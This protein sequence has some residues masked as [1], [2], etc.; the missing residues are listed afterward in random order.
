[1]LEK[2][3]IPTAG[4]G[5]RLLPATKEQPKEM[6]PVFV[7]A[8]NGLLYVKPFVQLVF[9]GLHDAG[10][11]NF[12][13][14][15]GRGKRSIEDHFTLD[16]NLAEHLSQTKRF[17][18]VN[19]LN[20]FYERIS[21]SNLVF[22]NQPEPKGFGDALLYARHF[23]GNKSFLVHAGDDLI[24]SRN[25]GCLRRLVQVLE[26][27]SADAVFC[28]Q[29]VRDPRKYGVVTGRE[30]NSNIYQVQAIEEKPL[31]PISDLAAIAVYAFSPKIFNAIE[32]T[33][34]DA[35]N[36]I[37]LT[38][39]IQHL[40]NKDCPVYALELK[41]DERRIDIGTPESYWNVLKTIRKHAFQ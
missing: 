25:N 24:L 32:N 13:F 39:A 35:N 14:I 18:I 20:S 17:E 29:R 7:R 23:A 4:L 41:E 6:L 36:E 12:C 21:Q 10:V 9:E 37:Q 31:A 27:Y 11:R 5:T 19:E 3:V 2:A 16:R 15:V 8:S 28:V 34:P 38:N 26:D 40:I 30:V 22:V 1:M 33:L